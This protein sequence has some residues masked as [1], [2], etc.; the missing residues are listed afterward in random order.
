M[1]V[2]SSQIELCQCSEEIIKTSNNLCGLH[3][4]VL[5]LCLCGV[6]KKREGALMGSSL[7]GASV[8]C[9]AHYSCNSRNLVCTFIITHFII[10]VI[11]RHRCCTN[12][13]GLD[14]SYYHSPTGARGNG[15]DY[16]G[17]SIAYY[18]V[19]LP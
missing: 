17:P 11:T 14:P 13:W 3:Y 5:A 7:L 12:L 6:L 19:V 15:E 2:K 18:S 1:S 8:D 9:L 4:H 16:N 10:I